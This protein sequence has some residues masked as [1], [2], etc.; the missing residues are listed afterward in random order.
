MI[1]HT[2]VVVHQ[3]PRVN[4]DALDTFVILWIGLPVADRFTDVADII[5]NA[6]YRITI[7]PHLKE[8]VILPIERHD[9]CVIKIFTRHT[10]GA[11]NV[12]SVCYLLVDVVPVRKMIGIT[13]ISISI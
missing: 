12:L 4:Y 2:D 6:R 1:W 11:L 10:L 7:S 8:G 5:C 9:K 3:K 13:A